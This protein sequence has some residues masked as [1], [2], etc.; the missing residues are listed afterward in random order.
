M[1]N[2]AAKRAAPQPERNVQ[3]VSDGLRAKF[4][5]GSAYNSASRP[6]AR[7]PGKGGARAPSH[8]R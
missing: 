3:R 5:R 2:E 1:G 4:H 7:Y 8:R 6:R